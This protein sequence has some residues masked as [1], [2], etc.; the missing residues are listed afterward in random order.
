[1]QELQTRLKTRFQINSGFRGR[2]NEF[3]QLRTLMGLASVSL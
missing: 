1:M 3:F 2:G